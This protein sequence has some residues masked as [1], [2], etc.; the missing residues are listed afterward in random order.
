ML[1]N[2]R[3]A[4]Y[5]PQGKEWVTLKRR[6]FALLRLIVICLTLLTLAGLTRDSLCEL[7]IKQ[8]S[9]EVTA[10]MAYPKTP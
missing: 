10:I 5:P 6:Y 7:H 4:F 8:P 9:V 2:I 3:L 1:H